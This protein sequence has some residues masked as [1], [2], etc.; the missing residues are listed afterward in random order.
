ML[1]RGAGKPVMAQEFG[2]SSAQFTPERIAR[3]YNT[4]M[5]SALGCGAHGLVAWCFTDADE[6]TWARVPYLRSPHET[7]FGV[8]DAHKR[9]RPAGEEMR[10][11]SRVLTQMEF[12]GLDLP[13][14]QAG[15]IVPHEFSHGPDHSRY[16]IGEPNL[17]LYVSAEEAWTEKRER[18][19]GVTLPVSSWLSA[20]VLARQAHLEVG[21]PREY[22]SW[23]DVPLILMPSPLTSTSLS[24]NHVHTT[25]WRRAQRYV[26]AGGTLYASLSGDAAIPE[27]Q[28][29]FGASLEDRIVPRDGV[30]IEMVRDFHGLERGQRFRYQAALSPAD[31]GYLL[32]VTGGEIIAVDQ[33]G[34]P[35]LVAHS[36]DRGR[37]LVSA[38]PVEHYL[39]QTP[40]AFDGRESTWTLYR[41]LKKY[42]GLGSP[43][44]CDDPR[45]ELSLLPR[46][47]E[48]Y[49]VVV[50]HGLEPIRAWISSA[51]SLEEVRELAPGGAK[52]VAH[53]ADGWEVELQGFCGT[54]FHW[55]AKDSD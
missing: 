35:A 23:E 38:Y 42:A 15:I 31:A 11:L 20:F 6:A 2:A 39:A 29:L 22:D 26:E 24:F 5:Y 54:V 40:A 17:S 43:F 48:G 51:L 52:G 13:P 21:F 53:S 12:E 55:R 44:D 45:V 7:Q 46:S 50:N 16:G 18:R 4:M 30:E 37:T 8:T 33:E 49:L 36:L 3:Y 32:H 25:F 1:A 34:N 27:M 19:S 41:A 9:D 10:K 14:L 47:S 28:D